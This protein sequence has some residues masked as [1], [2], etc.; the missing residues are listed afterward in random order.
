MISCI[1]FD[2]DGTLVDS[3]YLC[4]KGIAIKFKELGV[5]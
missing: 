3:E 2:N 4:N 5:N 1:L